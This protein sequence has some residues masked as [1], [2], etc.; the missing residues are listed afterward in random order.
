MEHFVSL[1]GYGGDLKIIN[2]VLIMDSYLVD[3]SVPDGTVGT[4]YSGISRSK[5][6]I[7]LHR[8]VRPIPRIFAT[9]DLFQRYF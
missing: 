5:R 6:R 2:S 8:V 7:F 3:H 1:G 9:F 4:S